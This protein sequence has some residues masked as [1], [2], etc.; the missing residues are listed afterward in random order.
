MLQ[1]SNTMVKC[2]STIIQLSKQRIRASFRTPNNWCPSV[3]VDTIIKR[4][5]IKIFLNVKH[6]NVRTHFKIV[7]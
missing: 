3:S 5:R 6:Q 7:N 2:K 1:Y 4:I